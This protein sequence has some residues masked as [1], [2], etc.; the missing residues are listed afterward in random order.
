MERDH[1]GFECVRIR[2]RRYNWKESFFMK[3]KLLVVNADDFGYSDGINRGIIDAHLRGIVTSVSAMIRESDILSM[4]VLS[5]FPRLSVGLHFFIEDKE[6]ETM[7]RSRALLGDST[8]IW[9]SEELERQWRLFERITGRNPSHIDSHHNIHFHPQ[10]MEIMAA[11]GL[12]N[13]V[14]IRNTYTRK[15]ITDFYGGRGA[16]NKDRVGVDALLKILMHL[17]CGVTELV[18]HPGLV[19]AELREKSS[20]TDLREAELYTLTDVTIIDFIH[21]S[22]IKLVNRIEVGY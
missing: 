21:A 1:R 2:A 11:Y 6:L 17:P 4:Q 12:K 20:Y 15:L 7:L 16:G 14:P 9:L 3:E 8:L 13:S 5:S 10:I 19:N 22:G 18:C